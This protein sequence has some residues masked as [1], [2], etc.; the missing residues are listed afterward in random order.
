MT[1]DTS[2]QSELEV[3]AEAEQQ[4]QLSYFLTPK[5]DVVYVAHDKESMNDILK[6][7]R[8][9]NLEFYYILGLNEPAGNDPAVM[10]LFQVNDNFVARSFVPVNGSVLELAPVKNTA[11]YKLAKLPWE[12]IQKV[13]TFFR[14]VDKDLGGSEAI[15]V[16][17]FDDRHDPHD[18]IGWRVIV[19]RQNNSA[20][21]CNYDPTSVADFI[22]DDDY[23]YIRQVGTIH[24]HP[25]M[26]AFASHTDEKDQATFDGLH[27]TIGWK[28]NLT[29][30]HA[31]IQAGG[32]NFEASP[33]LVIEIPEAEKK[34]YPEF[35]EWTTRVKK[36]NPVGPKGMGSGAT[37]TNWTSSSGPS[38]SNGL[39]SGIE[40]IKVPG[41]CPSL[42]EYTVVTNFLNP[43]D[44]LCPV[45]KQEMP[46]T[47][48]DLRRCRNCQTFVLF[49]D[50]TIADVIRIR[51]HQ[52]R[53]VY[54]LDKTEAKRTI[55]FWR[56]E[57]EYKTEVEF[58]KVSGADSPKVPGETDQTKQKPT[59]YV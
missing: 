17:A 10:T 51:E 20:A 39:Q 38:F 12:L 24:S 33:N 47:A 4:P 52:N 37:K 13:E 49:K 45:C 50:E 18:P 1:T 8:E 31:E 19:P 44:K 7:A 40:G 32:Q 21:H 58:I 14:K 57:T 48:I 23:D 36:E 54:E 43:S 11:L 9:S 55:A 42:T 25:G 46:E 22:D 56:R 6:D 16:L 59:P 41:G 2:N 27:I 5:G 35:D 26:S 29:E 53:P 28:G 15:V 34:D 3:P 30:F